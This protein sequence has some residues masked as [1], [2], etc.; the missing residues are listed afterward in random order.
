MSCLNF[1][2]TGSSFLLGDETQSCLVGNFSGWG[3]QKGNWSSW[4]WK[5]CV[6]SFPASNSGWPDRQGKKSMWCA[7]W[8]SR[9]KRHNTVPNEWEHTILRKNAHRADDLLNCYGLE[10]SKVNYNMTRRSEQWGGN[11]WLA[12]VR[13][14]PSAKSRETSLLSLVTQNTPTNQKDF[15]QQAG[16]LHWEGTGLDDLK[17]ASFQI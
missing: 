15:T 7:V 11:I 4:C 6:G 5:I 2:S 1:E 14:A 13:R 9:K 16:L 8:Q 17:G 12:H 10:D 3:P